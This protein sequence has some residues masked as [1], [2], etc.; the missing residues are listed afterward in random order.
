MS[1]FLTVGARRLLRAVVACSS[2]TACAGSELATTAIAGPEASDPK[3]PAS[4]TVSI[5]P[6][7]VAFGRGAV[8]QAVI[9]DVD[10]SV[11]E[12]RQVVWSVK[13]TDSVAVVYMTGS[14]S[15]PIGARPE[16]S[17]VLMVF[18]GRPSSTSSGP[19]EKAIPKPLPQCV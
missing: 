7:I 4:I 19:R 12:G 14:I 16:S 1:G 15:I 6:P 2:L 18:M 11:I 17:R 5:D 8:A 10:G 3:P 9:R 13:Q